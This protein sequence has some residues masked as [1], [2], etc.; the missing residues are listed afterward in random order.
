MWVIY[1]TDFSNAVAVQR[2]FIFVTPFF[3]LCACSTLENV[4]VYLLKKSYR[5]LLIGSLCIYA[6]AAVQARSFLAVLDWYSVAGVAMTFTLIGVT[7]VTDINEQSRKRYTTFI[8]CLIVM[9]ATHSRM[10]VLILPTLLVLGSLGMSVR[11]RIVILILLAC[12]GIYFFGSRP[13][14]ENLFHRGYGTVYDAFSFN[15][16]IVNFSGRLTVWPKFVQG[17][18]NIWLGDGSTASA[19]FGKIMF[20]HMGWSHPH[21]AYIRVLFD[22]GITGCV[23]LAIPVISLLVALYKRYRLCRTHEDLRWIY[24]ASIN[25]IVAMLL[26]G[27]SGNVLMYVA[28][29]GNMLF[30]T[31][32]CA[33]AYED[34]TIKTGNPEY[35]NMPDSQQVWQTQRRRS[36]GLSHN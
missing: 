24:S 19:E 20:D 32:G 36:N 3:V 10:P 18:E 25:G 5:L 27:I 7:A 6:F 4:T 34:K 1:K 13:V 16:E 33:F 9:L 14:Q 23:L 8:L 11:V 12:A 29:I 17:I 30:A 26:L 15:P 35:E 2:L 28:F 22:Y 31:I 21:N